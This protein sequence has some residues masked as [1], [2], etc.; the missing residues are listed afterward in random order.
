MGS[1]GKVRAPTGFR[2]SD[3][4]AVQ[5]V[6]TFRAWVSIATRARPY[7][8]LGDAD[9]QAVADWA[10]ETGS[11][12][13]L[14]DYEVAAVSNKTVAEEAFNGDTRNARKG[15]EHLIDAGIIDK[16]RSGTRGHA[17]LYVT[18]PTRADVAEGGYQPQ[19]PEQGK[20]EVFH[21]RG[22]ATDPRKSIVENSNKGV[23]RTEYGGHHPL[24]GGSGVPSDLGCRDTAGTTDIYNRGGAPLAAAKAAPRPEWQKV[25]CPICNTGLRPRKSVDGFQ[26]PG[27][28][29]TYSAD[30]VAELARSQRQAQRR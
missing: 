7:A 25:W 16:A 27:C 18:Y 28:L 24:I 19:E 3:A 23:T 29:R 21:N 22:V 1:W 30:K 10:A 4:L 6:T 12:V 5:P 17:S 11:P 20:G 2:L 14:G 13:S 9:A 8:K 15:I 26:C